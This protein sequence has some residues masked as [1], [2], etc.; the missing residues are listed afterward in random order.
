MF[1][2]LLRATPRPSTFTNVCHRT[3]SSHAPVLKAAE[4]FVSAEM[5]GNDGSHDMAHVTRVRDL[6]MRLA[7]DPTSDVASDDQDAMLVVELGAMLHD[8]KDFKYS[9]SRTAGPDSVRAF[10]EAHA[11]ELTQ[12]V[13]DRVVH[14]VANVSYSKEVAIAAGAPAPELTPELAVVQVR[15]L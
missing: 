9:G 4:A 2:Q 10:L 8:V 11:D 14:V 6:A 12:D 7:Q 5:E 13:I 3:M 15:D 1:K